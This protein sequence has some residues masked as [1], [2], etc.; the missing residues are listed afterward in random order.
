[1]RRSR[2]AGGWF[3]GVAAGVS[4]LL[5][6]ADPV[7]AD[8]TEGTYD[9]LRIGYALLEES[10]TAEADLKWL[11][12]LRELTLQGPAKEVERLMTTIREASGK[13]ANELA[14]L[15]KL[16]PDVTGEG[17]ASLI[18]NAIQ[19]AAKWEGTKEMLFPDGQF[20]MRFI[21][22]QAQATRMISVIA[23]QAAKIDPNPER[24]KWLE[25]VSKEY[26]DYREELVKTVER[27]E[28]R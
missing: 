16:P 22:L 1:M 13:R 4:L 18:G 26:A 10:L 3:V 6:S 7:A 20:G 15:R 24:E 9:D 5:S 12:W 25:A 28:L 2:R 21:F 14:N 8:S 19:A 11:L 27:C 23:E 17:P